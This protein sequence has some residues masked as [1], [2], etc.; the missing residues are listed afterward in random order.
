M[1]VSYR[2]KLSW[3]K[4]DPDP[5]QAQIQFIAGSGKIKVEPNPYRNLF[6]ERW[7]LWKQWFF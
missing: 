1:Y 2:H 5:K 4:S 6:I 3:A 7:K